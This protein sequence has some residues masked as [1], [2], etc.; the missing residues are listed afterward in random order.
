MRH[1]ASVLQIRWHSETS[2]LDYGRLNTQPHTHGSKGIRVRGDLN[3][4][5]PTSSADCIRAGPPRP[6]GV[7]LRA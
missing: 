4:T 3:A 6:L 1:T 5:V 7:P 2:E